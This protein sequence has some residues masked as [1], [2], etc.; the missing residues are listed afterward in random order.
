MRLKLY[1]TQDE[2]I[3]DLY[4]SGKE[5]MTTDNV[6]YV[7]L[8]HRYTTGETYTGSTWNSKTSVKL[9]P[10]RE[11]NLLVNQYQKLKRLK[12]Q[13]KLPVSRIVTP[14]PEQIKQGEM[15]RYFIKKIN[16]TNITEIDAIQFQEWLSKQIDPALYVGAELT[17]YIS[18]NVN[19]TFDGTRLVR[20][21]ASKNKLQLATAELTI[22]GITNRLANLTE[23]YTDTVY[24]VPRDINA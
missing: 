14:T 6:Q 18:G 16:E 8:Y 10:F 21:V 19:D 12:L 2:I 7:G 13:Y 3:A 23:F 20:G 1:Y 9:I 22:P 17:W 24:T 5:W 4:T 15:L 11:Q